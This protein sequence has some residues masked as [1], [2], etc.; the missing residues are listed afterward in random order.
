MSG[1]MARQ[2]F[3]SEV[4]SGAAPEAIYAVLSDLHTHLTWAGEQAPRKDFR[5]LSM[6][7]PAGQLTVGDT[8]SSTGDNGNGVFHDRSVVVEAEPGRRFGFDTRSTLERRHGKTWYGR[9]THRYTI[10]PADGGGSQI[11]LESKVYP[12]NYTPWWLR[13]GFRT[14]AR[15][16]IEHFT[17]KQLDNLSAMAVEAERSTE[18]AR[19]AG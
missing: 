5:L 12:E 17:P 7:A 16:L 1:A 9:F 2:T 8:F 10:E 6:V 18:D 11:R 19:R 14:M 13:A 3:R 4:H 15:M